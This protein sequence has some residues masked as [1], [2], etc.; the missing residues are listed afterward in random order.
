M[1]WGIDAC[2]FRMP[3]LNKPWFFFKCDTEWWNHGSMYNCI[4]NVSYRWNNY[5]FQ[6]ESV[7]M[8]ILHF[9]LDELAQESLDGMAKK[10]FMSVRAIC[11]RKLKRFA[12]LRHS[13]VFETFL[14]L[15]DWICIFLFIVLKIV[16]C[17]H[18]MIYKNFL[19]FVT[20]YN[21]SLQI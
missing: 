21:L 18:W 6:L 5:L 2:P 8:F 20:P 19:F 16:G 10:S 3:V 9:F 1:T 14:V 12:N 17:T 11:C 7:L 13:S 4:C 15:Y